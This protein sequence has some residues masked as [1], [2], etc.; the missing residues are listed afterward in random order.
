MGTDLAL[1]LTETDDQA[2]HVI[3]EA[4]RALAA[5]G[6]SDLVWGHVSVRDPGGRGMWMKQAGIGFEEVTPD[7][8]QLIAWDGSVLAGHGPRH[9]EFHIHAGVYARRPDVASVTHAHSDDVNA[10]CALEIPLLPLTHAG[11]MFT[12]PQLPR[13]RETMNLIRTPELGARLAQDLGGSIGILIPQHG[14]VMTGADVATSVI[15]AVMLERAAA[16]HLAALSAGEV[17][18]WASDADRDE[19][20]WPPSQVRA[21]YDFLVR[22]AERIN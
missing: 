13:F 7:R 11:M 8:V 10:W 2:R 18:D 20:V 15:R 14:F 1:P 9:I 16:V 21:G 6:L 3:S 4:S 5:A 12:D 22:R 17:R 19:F